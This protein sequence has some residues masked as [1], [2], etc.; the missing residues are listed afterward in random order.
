LN[1]SRLE[2]KIDAV[3]EGVQFAWNRG[4]L[5]GFPLLDVSVHLVS[6]EDSP[7]VTST[8][9]KTGASMIVTQAAENAEPVILE[10]IMSV[11]IT[12][13]KQYAHAIETGLL[14]GCRALNL[15]KEVQGNSTYVFYAEVPLKEMMT[16]STTLRSISKGTAFFTMEFIR[17]AE[18]GHVE[19][20]EVLK[21]LGM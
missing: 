3:E 5:A 20:E 18:V 12:A 7:Q 1:F 6:F 11:E 19:S 14:G 13:D 4:L 15:S 9:L 8:A 16:Y 17:Y 21:S 10:P 2:K